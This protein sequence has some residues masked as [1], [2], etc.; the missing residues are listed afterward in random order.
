MRPPIYLIAVLVLAPSMAQA[1]NSVSDGVQALVGGDYQNAARILR[2]LAEETAQ[3]DPLAQFFMA[4]LYASGL[5]VD[6]SQTKAC[7]LYLA[8]ARPENPL[9][10]QSLMVARSLQE[11]WSQVGG[12]LGAQLC[13]SVAQGDRGLATV[14]FELGPGHR[15]TIGE[16]GA[17]VTYD[18]AE[19]RT[20]MHNGGPGFVYLPVQHTVLTVSSPASGLR[21]FLQIFCWYRSPLDPG[22]WNLGWSLMEVVKADLIPVTGDPKVTTVTAAEPPAS[23]DVESVLRLNVGEQGEAEWTIFDAPSPRRGSIPVKAAAR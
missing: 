2:P 3:P 23:F 15:V 4:M 8:A 18:G 11:Q 21:H 12:R 9:A 20:I 1:Q 16:T 13:S 17:T 14:T 22:T 6:A 7:G 19:H 5:G 10:N